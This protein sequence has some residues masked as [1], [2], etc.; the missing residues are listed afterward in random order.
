M[1][2]TNKRQEDLI[3][4]LNKL[5]KRANQRI[6]TIERLTNRKSPQFA[7]KDLADYLSVT[8]GLTKRKGKSVRV[9]MYKKSMT[10]TDVLGT[11]KALN[12]FLNY[13]PTSKIRGIKEFTKKQSEKL[14]KKLTFA[15]ASTIYR[16]R[17]EWKNIFDYVNESEFWNYYNITFRG[18]RGGGTSF[19]SFYSDMFT[20]WRDT[21]KPLQTD[22]NKMDK[23]TL[24]LLHKVYDYLT[25]GD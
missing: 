12:K 16:A 18:V 9:S 11:I 23:D 2:V 15:Q 5:S 19:E 6:L 21:E 8:K 13:E 24:D 25:K 10:E 22:M 4:E 20:L 7:V 14:G 3:S 17:N 1:E